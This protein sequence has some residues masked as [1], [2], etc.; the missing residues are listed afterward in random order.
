MDEKQTRE[1]LIDKQLKSVGWLKSYI[2]EEVN[3]VR[4]KFK[5]KEY[6]LSQSQGD[7]SGRF[8]D[9]L[10]LAEDNSPIALI[11]AKKFSVSEDKGR[12]QARTYQKDIESQIG[13]RIPVFLTNGHKWLFIDQDGVERHV[14]GVFSQA[15][16][17]RRMELFRKRRD[18][19][20][21][22][23]DRIVDRPRSVLVVKQLMEHIQKGYRSALISM[24]TGT[25]KTRVAMSMI[26]VLLRANI[27]R[28]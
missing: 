1:Q 19:T 26:D 27:V 8:I 7:D 5:I 11:E 23:I 21:I 2:K 22:S 13:E 14:S 15:D 17:K 18:P 9:Y 28:N 24:A 6:I 16:L 12:A 25:G 4:S 3:S 10:L 20:K